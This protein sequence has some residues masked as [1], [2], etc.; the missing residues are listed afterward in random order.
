MRQ[1]QQEFEGRRRRWEGQQRALS[2]LDLRA[3]T[4]EQLH[5]RLMYDA[6]A[7]T[8]KV[9]PATQNIKPV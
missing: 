9:F 7:G 4:L 8:Y 6:R 3:S 1:L 2:E 5:E